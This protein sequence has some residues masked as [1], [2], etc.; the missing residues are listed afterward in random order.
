MQ[1][2]EVTTPQQEKEWIL[3]PVTLYKDDPNFIRHIDREVMD[4]FDPK[5]NKFYTYEGSE[6]VRWLLQRDGKTIGRIAAFVNGKTARL[7]DFPVGGCGFFDCINDQQAA[8]MLFDAAR[9]WLRARGME[10]MDGPVNF[11]ERDKYW[12]VL[13][14][15][16]EEQNYGMNYNAPYYKALFENYGFGLYFNQH[17]FGRDSDPKNDLDPSFYEK[18]RPALENP[19]ITFR[20]IPKSEF[21][22]APEYFL[23]V[24]TKAWGGHKGVKPMNIEQARKIFQKLKPI[25]DPKLIWF[26][27]HK[28]Q[29]I[30]FYISIPELNQLFK[31]VDGN[32]NWWGK[33]KFLYHKL[34]GRNTKML[35][36]VFGVV[37]EWH[38]KGIET[39]IVVA[40]SKL[41]W[42]EGLPYKQVEMNWIGD[43]NPK[44]MRVCENLGASIIR[45]H[46]TYRYLF[47]REKPFERCPIIE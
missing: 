7:E 41:I 4:V 24:Y 31:Y 2:I 35:G 6:T 44:M 21:G 46:A 39:A 20:Y 28:E 12:G 9:D 47:D 16:F 5:V 43:F 36:I 18:A 8:N 10:A 26:G 14:D 32:M 3:F 13:I 22:K 42:G 25:A 17:T 37:P 23:E 15:G 34:R 33:L 30:A 1:L 29:P 11:G 38:G 45:T 19:D 40:F 27:F